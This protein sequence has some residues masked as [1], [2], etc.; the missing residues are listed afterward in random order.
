MGGSSGSVRRQQTKGQVQT[1]S[2]GR[3]FRLPS[4]RPQILPPSA[5]LWQRSSRRHRAALDVSSLFSL[6]L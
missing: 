1:I 5:E 6:L 4:R 3:A 2:I